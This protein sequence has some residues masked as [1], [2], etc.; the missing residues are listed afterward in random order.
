MRTLFPSL[1]AAVL[2]ASFAFTPATPVNAAPVIPAKPEV[3]KSD[4]EQVRHRKWRKHRHWRAE[5]RWRR[6]ALRR[7]YY[8]DYYYDDWRYPRYH[9]YYRRHRPGFSF[10]FSF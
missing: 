6:Y 4:I 9:R 2:A 1:T 8:D 7:H 10:Y 3:T 5:R